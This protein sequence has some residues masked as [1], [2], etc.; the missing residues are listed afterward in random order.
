MGQVYLRDR[1]I[2]NGWTI[3]ERYKNRGNLPR[4]VVAGP[5]GLYYEEFRRLAGAE[6]WC[7]GNGDVSHLRE[8]FEHDVCPKCSQPSQPAE[9]VPNQALRQC[10][11]C[12]REFF[13]NLLEPVKRG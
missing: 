11:K 8:Q 6:K 10:R 1:K 9:R 2:V 13:E 5:D 7:R 4:Y 3:K 12:G